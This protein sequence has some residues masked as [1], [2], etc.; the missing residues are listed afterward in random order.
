MR[1]IWNANIKIE[2]SRPNT[3]F[4]P[5]FT[6]CKKLSHLKCAVIEHPVATRTR[7][8]VKCPEQKQSATGIRQTQLEIIGT[9]NQGSTSARNKVSSV[10][11]KENCYHVEETDSL[12]EFVME[13]HN[14]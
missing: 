9:Q 10:L 5:F 6:V 12:A 11:D 8:K 7:S 2:R 14:A 4:F 3:P 13:V 1:N